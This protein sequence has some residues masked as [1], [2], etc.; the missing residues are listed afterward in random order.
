MGL[1]VTMHLREGSVGGG[2][3]EGGCYWMGGVF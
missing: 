3:F 1:Q 2:V